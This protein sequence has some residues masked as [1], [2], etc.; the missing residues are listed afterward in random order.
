MGG[1][2]SHQSGVPS[3]LPVNLADPAELRV[4]NHEACRMASA[5]M[6]MSGAQVRAPYLPRQLWQ[7]VSQPNRSWR[8]GSTSERGLSQPPWRGVRCTGE[9]LFWRHCHCRGTRRRARLIWRLRTELWTV[10]FS[11][12]RALG[13]MLPPSEREIWPF[14]V[15]FSTPTP[16]PAGRGD[17]GCS[18]ISILDCTCSRREQYCWSTST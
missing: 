7:G 11:R 8:A 6:L 16:A 18:A 2:E 1:G 14:F 15:G 10:L 5:P 3:Q 12:S 4:T 9:P 17:Y 13:P